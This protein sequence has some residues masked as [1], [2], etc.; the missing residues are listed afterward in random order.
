MEYKDYYKVLGVDRSASED[1]IKRSYRKL[2]LKYH[3]DR[4][5]DDKQAEDKF[6]EINEAYQV[7]SD[8]EKRARYNQLGES[9][10]RWQQRGGAPGGFNWD[11]WFTQ[12]TGGPGGRQG[13]VRVEVGDLG[14]LFGG[15]GMGGFS[16]FFR[17]IFG[18]MEDIGM[19][20]PGQSRA[21][22]AAPRARRQSYEQPVTISL[23]EAYQGTS[24]R[25][26]VDGRQLEVKIPPGARS[27]TKVRVSDA[28]TTDN[29]QTADLFLIVEVAPDPRFERRGSDLYT[30]VEVD[31]YTAVLGGEVTVPTMSGNVVLKIPPGT[32]PGQSMR[33]SGRGMPQLK[34]PDR[35]GDLYARIKVRLPRDLTPHQREL[36]EQLSQT[37]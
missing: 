16:E 22:R 37:G 5:P 13:N 30:D 27:K 3:P 26:Q 14:D 7:L 29:G 10:T 28:I 12:P 20:Y 31:L 35:H 4:N 33:L 25:I 15:G 21:T 1:E 34:N 11:D 9:Y 19:G 32:Q 18:G 2:A 36:F 23:Q 17:R 8:P 6:K 24:R